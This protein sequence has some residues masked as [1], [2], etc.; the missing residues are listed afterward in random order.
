MNNIASCFSKQIINHLV[1]STFIWVKLIVTHSIEGSCFLSDPNFERE[2]GLNAEFPF[3]NSESLWVQT[4][5][6]PDSL[7]RGELKRN[8]SKNSGT[9]RTRRGPIHVQLCPDARAMTLRGY[10]G[11]LDRDHNVHRRSTIWFR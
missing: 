5:D 3:F 10:R 8:H 2:V 9:S 7:W 4:S 6:D 11:I 1:R